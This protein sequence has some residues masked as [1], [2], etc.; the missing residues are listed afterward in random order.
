M[1]IQKFKT[2]YDALNEQQKEAVNIYNDNLLI[3]AGA[4]TGKTSTIT[5]RMAYLIYHVCAPEN[6]LAVT[7]TNKAAQE[8]K[9]RAINLTYPETNKMIVG[10]FHGVSLKVLR[11]YGSALNLQENFLIL[12]EYD[13]KKAPIWRNQG[14]RNR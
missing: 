7:F 1:D 5:S 2:V 10:T 13:K 11:A 6:I 9:R 8:M 14:F 3:V 4:G 12:D